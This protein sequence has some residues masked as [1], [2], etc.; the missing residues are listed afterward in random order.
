MWR[1]A[2]WWLIKG[3]QRIFYRSHVFRKGLAPYSLLLL[4]INSST[5][6]WLTV[7]ERKKK[8]ILPKILAENRLKWMVG[9]GKNGWL[10]IQMSRDTKTDECGLKGWHFLCFREIVS[11]AC[12]I[13][14]ICIKLCIL[15][16]LDPL[17][18]L[19]ISLKMPRTS[20][21][22]IGPCETILLLWL[23]IVITFRN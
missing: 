9:C 21:C 5:S 17:L 2:H 20:L 8:S 18:R 16:H 22:C 12:W 7:F 23:Q 15:T 6:V 19:C 4:D 1:R 11:V 3:R 13:F 14:L 10:V